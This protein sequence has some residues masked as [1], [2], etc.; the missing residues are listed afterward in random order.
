MSNKLSKNA[1]GAKRR[2]GRSHGPDFIQLFR[3]VLHS[4]A[5]ISLSAIARAALIE[6][7]LGYNGSNNGRI[8]LSVRTVAE[9]MGCA[10]NTAMRALQELVDKG[11]IEPRIKGAFSVKFR[12]A[13]E[14][15]L[16][17]RRCD[18]TGAE[19]S[20]A[21]LKWPNSV[22]QDQSKSR[23]RS[24]KLRPYGLKNE[25]TRNFLGQ[26]ERS[27]I[28]RHYGAFHGLKNEDT[29]ISTSTTGSVC[30]AG[31][32]RSPIGVAA[33]GGVFPRVADAALVPADHLRRNSKSPTE[34]LDGEDDDLR[35]PDFLRRTLIR[36]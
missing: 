20:Q 24:Q 29:S 12:R 11:F 5:Y 4:P 17:D 23:T 15:R 33:E 32:V 35:I 27:Q 18:A 8:V 7:N 30:A 28:L 36:G 26:P 10:N 9:R 1:G 22:F 2:R 34:R 3:Y 13:T 14:W 21:F 25:D 19:Q 31:G 6:V 16:N